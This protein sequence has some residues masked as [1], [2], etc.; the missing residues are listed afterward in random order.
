MISFNSLLAV[1][2]IIEK[3]P[4]IALVAIVV[5]F[6]FAFMFGVARGYHKVGKSACYWGAS[7][8]AF[9]LMYRAL[10]AKNPLDQILKGRAAGCSGFLWALILVACAIFG[11]LIV[12][13]ILNL[14]FR[15][16]KDVW[17]AKSTSTDY[18]FE[19]E[20]DNLNTYPLNDMREMRRNARREHKGPGFMSR[21]FGGLFCAGSV[22]IVLAALAA[23][24]VVIID[25]TKLGEGAI[26][27]MFEG[28]VGSYILNYSKRF[29]L[30]FITVGIIFFVTYRG[31]RVGLVGFAHAVFKRV[32]IVIVVIVGLAIPFIDKVSS[33]YFIE[34]LVD[35][36][37]A[38]FAKM[39]P[40][41]SGIVS[42]LA[43]GCILALAGAIVIWLL[44]FLFGKLTEDVEETTV[45][46][47]IDGALATLIYFILG[48]L[49]C[50]LFWAGMYMLNEAGVLVL[51]GALGESP[52]LAK[53]CLNAADALLHDFV[54]N[55]LLRWK[56]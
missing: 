53:E 43:A 55:Y 23:L 33:F 29:A 3:L 18:A 51:E 8:L 42:K 1:K 40:D 16:N 32:G 17:L 48:A 22:V 10:N 11:V 52:S 20:L 31:F 24:G 14:V 6:V 26:G 39:D 25:A 27:G 30:D 44:A 28:K 49:L 45:L 41:I 50:A 34:K 38:L 37:S 47:V 12:F 7:G 9:L 13:G 56:A 19:Y 5:L 46:F 36:C 2:D 15:E 35:R 4:V 54:E 21:L